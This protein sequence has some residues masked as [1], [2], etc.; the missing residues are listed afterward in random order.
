MVLCKLAGKDLSQ[1]PMITIHRSEFNVFSNTTNILF[2]FS[3]QR[4]IILN[5]VFNFNRAWHVI[6]ITT[7][8]F[9]T[10]RNPSHIL[11]YC[12]SSWVS[13]EQVLVTQCPHLTSL[14]LH[15]QLRPISSVSCAADAYVTHNQC[16]VQT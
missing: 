11:H 7:K 5:T 2:P 10:I 9:P 13:G 16:V 3:R 12:L 6:K 14:T 15:K 8:L 1:S 4:K